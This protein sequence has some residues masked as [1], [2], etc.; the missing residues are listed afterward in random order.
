MLS[1]LLADL[2]AKQRLYQQYGA[3]CSLLK[4]VLADGTLA[5]T[6]YRL[7]GQLV[8]LKLTPL[9]LLPHWLNKWVNGCV[10]GVKAQFGPGFV[11]VHPV[12]VVINSAVRGGSNICLESSVV[13]GDNRG[14][15][16]MLGDDVFVGSGAKIIGGLT[17][18]SGARVGANAVVLH[19]VPA[20]A[21][22]VGIPARCKPAATVT[23]E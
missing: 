7:Q 10:I 4:A 11:L 14:G 3:S 2:R 19:D 22:A 1:L 23:I 18:G 9:A 12:G 15:V 8:A 21:T 16:P 20:G 6:L 13:I 5:S 17:I